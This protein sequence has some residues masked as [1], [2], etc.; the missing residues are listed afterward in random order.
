MVETVQMVAEAQL[1][2]PEP[3]VAMVL[4][5]MRVVMASMVSTVPLDSRVAMVEMVWTVAEAPL[6]ETASRQLGSTAGTAWMVALGERVSMVSMVSMAATVWL[7]VMALMAVMALLVA[8]ALSA[9][10]A[11]TD[12]WDVMELMDEM[13]SKVEEALPELLDVMASSQRTVFRH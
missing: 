3:L 5:A 11:S 2:Q 4:T 10:M 1:G 12:T 13:A 9:M 8:E 7:G 6:V